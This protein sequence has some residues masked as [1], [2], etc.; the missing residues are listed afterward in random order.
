M[1]APQNKAAY[2]IKTGTPLE[3]RD[4][5]LPTAG[6]GQIVVKNAAVAINPLD[7]HMLDHGVFVQQWPAIFGCDVAGE[8]Y[9]VGPDVEEFKK[10]DRVIG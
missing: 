10:G 7:W 3:V 9:Q 2:L 8:V 4:A 6:P 5:P 1:D